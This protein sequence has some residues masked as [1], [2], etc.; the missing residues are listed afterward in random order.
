MRGN[1]LGQRAYP[2]EMGAVSLAGSLTNSIGD[3]ALHMKGADE[4][5]SLLKKTV[6]NINMNWTYRKPYWP[7]VSDRWPVPT[8]TYSN[9]ATIALIII[10]IHAYFFDFA[11]RFAE[12]I[13]S[14]VRNPKNSPIT[15]EKV[16]V[17]VSSTFNGK[18]F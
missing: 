6:I 16:R 18:V 5:N 2:L 17:R 9:V 13:T 10:F 15:K 12:W 3:M 14:T 8:R 4:E 7:C 11:T 1:I